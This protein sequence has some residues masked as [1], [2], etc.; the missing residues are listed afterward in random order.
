MRQS[1]KMFYGTYT[2][3][4]SATQGKEKKRVFTSSDNHPDLMNLAVTH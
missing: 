3:L 1:R 4:A 2:S